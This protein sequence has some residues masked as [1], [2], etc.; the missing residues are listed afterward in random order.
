MSTLSHK[1]VAACMVTAIS[2][3][4]YGCGGGGGSSDT[5]MMPEPMP[6]PMC[7]DTGQVGTYPDCMDPAPPAPPGPTYDGPKTAMALDAY[8]K[9]ATSNK[10]VPEIAEETASSPSIPAI[11]RAV[12]GTLS[13]EDGT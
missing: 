4:M 10:N 6:D 7:S 11:T 3:V 2:M 8:G 9:L 1:L 5:T 13:F 12:D